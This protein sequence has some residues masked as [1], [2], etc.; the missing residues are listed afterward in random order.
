MQSP[1]ADY[2]RGSVPAWLKLGY[3]LGTPIVAALYARAYGPKNFLWL[4]DLALASTAAAV[5]GENALPASVAAVGA[6]PLEIAW[7]LDFA[8]GGRLFGL[9]GYMFDRKLP[10][11][12]RA[13]SLFHVA[14]PPTLAFLLS[15]LGYDRR[16]LPLAAAA[17]TLVLPLSYL[18]TDA[19]AN[20]N[21]VFG[22]GR[23]AQRRLPPLVYLGLEMLALPLLVFL[24]MHVL[25]ARRFGGLDRT[26]HD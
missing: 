17:T 10:R 11:W 9:A 6:L 5:I 1:A 16:A 18:L 22:P 7:N 3:G 23:R 14:L 24:P 26:R 15:R 21:W 2:R 19:E 8:S 25:L 4:S 12:L 20:T 13:L